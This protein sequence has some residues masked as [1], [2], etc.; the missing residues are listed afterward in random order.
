MSKVS[1]GKLGLTKNTSTKIIKYKEQEIEVRQYLPVSEKLDLISKVINLSSDGNDDFANPIKVTIYATLEIIKTYCNISF[2]EKQ[3]EDVC[4]AYDL[5]VSNGLSSVIFA[6][7][8]AEE[9]NEL[10]T[11]IEDSINSIYNYRNSAMGILSIIANDYSNLHLDAETIKNNI[12]N[13]DNLALLRD[14]LTKLG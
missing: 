13:P 1:F 3:L 6:A 2:T 8:P 14:I 11:G 12:G 5:F 9:L 10:L 4:K 7:I